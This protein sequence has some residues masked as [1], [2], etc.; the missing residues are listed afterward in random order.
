MNTLLYSL[1]AIIALLIL[2]IVLLYKRINT[3]F[4]ENM[5]QTK[6]IRGLEKKLHEAKKEGNQNNSLMEKMVISG[7]QQLIDGIKQKYEAQLAEKDRIINDLR[8]KQDI[9]YC[10]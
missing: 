7:T 3:L 10:H 1:I 2:A 9:S 5:A 4:D 6:Q 8:H